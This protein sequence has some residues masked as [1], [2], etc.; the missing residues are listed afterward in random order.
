MK[1][2]WFRENGESWTKKAFTSIPLQYSQKNISSVYTGVLN[3][4]ACRPIRYAEAVCTDVYKRQLIFMGHYYITLIFDIR[5]ISHFCPAVVDCPGIKLCEC[6]RVSASI[7][8]CLLYTSY[9]LQFWSRQVSCPLSWH[10]Q[11]SYVPYCYRD[12][13]SFHFFIWYWPYLSQPLY[14]LRGR[15]A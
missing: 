8:I 4:S 6:L 11:V 1:K 5:R 3:I 12:S 2:V 10:L 9:C 13:G 7:L 14:F 15:L